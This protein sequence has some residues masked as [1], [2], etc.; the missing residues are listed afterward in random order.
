MLLPH[1][2]AFN[3]AAAPGAIRRLGLALGVEHPA[4]K[5]F[6]LAQSLGA[7]SSLKAI[8]MPRDGVDRVIDTLLADPAW[9]PRPLEAKPLK[10]M[11]RRAFDGARPR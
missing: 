7:P 2:L 8:G 5:L 10:T 9:N 1:V 11:L 4:Q 6:D 3:A